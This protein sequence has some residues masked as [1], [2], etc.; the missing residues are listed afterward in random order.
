MKQKIRKC[1][2]VL[3]IS[4]CTLSA[5]LNVFAETNDVV[6]QPVAQSSDEQVTATQQSDS[7]KKNEDVAGSAQQEETDTSTI[8]KQATVNGESAD[9]E[10]GTEKEEQTVYYS[11]SFDAADGILTADTTPTLDTQSVASG[12]KALAPSVTKG[13]DYTFD[14]WYYTD[15]N[16]Q[17]VKWNFDDPVTSDLKL[18]AQYTAKGPATDSQTLTEQTI[19][20]ELDGKTFHI[21]GKM[22]EGVSLRVSAA[23]IQAFE[24]TIE[25]SL[26]NGS[27][28]KASWAY[29]IKIMMA[30]GTTEFQPERVGETVQVSI[31]DVSIPDDAQNTT[32]FHVK[33]DNNAV[34]KIDATVTDS[35]GTPTNATENVNVGFDTKS[36]SVFGPV[37]VISVP[38]TAASTTV[39]NSTVNW[40]VSK[41]KT[42]SP[43]E[44]DNNKITKVTLS[45]PSAEEEL[46]SDV[47][48]VLDSSSCTV[49]VMMSLETMMNNLYASIAK[50]QAKLNIG[51]IMFRGNAITAYPLTAYTG[52]TT[53]IQSALMQGL[54]D[55]DEPSG[56]GNPNA[57]HGSN[58][59]SGLDAAK[60]MLDG[61]NSTSNNRKNM[62]LVSDGATY[63]YTHDNDP[64]TC[65]SRTSGYAGMA[66]SLYEYTAKYFPEAP[67]GGNLSLPSNFTDWP[68]FLSGIAATRDNYTQY[69]AQYS[70]TASGGGL[71]P[72]AIN[73]NC[74]KDNVGGF[75]INVD[76]SLYQSYLDFKS[77][78]EEK[79]NCYAVSADTSMPVFNSFINYLG[80]ALGRGT[81][82]DFTNIE[83][84]IRFLINKGSVTDVIGNDFDLVNN[85]TDSPFTITL[86]GNVLDSKPTGTNEWSFGNADTSGVYPYI[87]TYMPGA[88]EQFV[89]KINVPVENAYPLQL[90]YNL[91]L[92]ASPTTAGTYTYPTNESAT[93]EYTSSDESKT[94][95]E[96]FEKPEVTFTVSG[97]QTTETTTTGGGSEYV[98]VNKYPAVIDPPVQKLLGGDTPDI[99]SAFSFALKADDPKYPMPS[100]SSNGVKMMNITGAGSSEFGKIAYY[101]PGTY[102]YTCYEVNNGIAGYTYDTSTFT[103]KVVVVDA[104]DRLLASKT[105]VRSNGNAADGFAFGNWYTKTAVAPAV[106]NNA[107]A[108]TNPD[109]PKTADDL[110]LYLFILMFAAGSIGIVALSS[111]ILKKFSSNQ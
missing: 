1:L 38:S 77:L 2:A 42:A 47:V 63:L 54:Y 15:E 21:S 18:T 24:Q 78:T 69:D 25:N 61:D 82:T 83:K 62:I 95:T 88:Q 29:D 16:N 22:P 76:E 58:M 49:N 102:T 110:P 90:S 27:T 12:E 52:D 107:P 108:P 35:N 44:L 104:G 50:S 36:F 103:M 94:G 93:L 31:E 59:P 85:G 79:I 57:L 48:F 106:V 7:S 64:T 66:G 46:S 19:S 34:E 101:Q 26:G 43:T 72:N 75:T 91:L 81:S 74:T 9:A 8:T 6:Q 39:L 70:R 11:V 55:L 13:E 89:W 68:T 14:G 51:I 33:D 32:V 84:T 30:D 97:G 99:A 45:I 40:Q 105:I 109:V 87:V 96:I 37:T 65:Y 20:A 80:G 5:N 3:L 4:A 53:P 56:T 73:P 92:T 41:S 71:D 28:V 60:K 23:D 111:T 17:P 67:S 98:P 86:S 100:G 10:N